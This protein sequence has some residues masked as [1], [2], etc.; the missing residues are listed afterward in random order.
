MAEKS[1]NWPGIMGLGEVSKTEN[2]NVYWGMRSKKPAKGRIT[3]GITAY[4]HDLDPLCCDWTSNLMDA[5]LITPGKIENGGI[6]DVLPDELAQY[7][8]CHFFSGIAGWD[9]ALNLA[10]WGARKVFTGSVPCQPFSSAGEGKGFADERHLWPFFH[11]IIRECRPVICFGEQV[12][13]AIEKLWLDLLE[14]DLEGIGYA[15]GAQVFPACS[16]GAHHRR[17]RL[18][19]VADSD[20]GRHA[21]AGARAGQGQGHDAMRSGAADGMALA[22][23]DQQSGQFH[24]GESGGEGTGAEDREGR[25][26]ERQ[27]GGRRVPD[28]GMGLADGFGQGQRRR[29]EGPGQGE[30]GR[31]S[32]DDGNFWDYDAE[33]RWCRDGKWRPIKRN[34]LPLV[35]GVHGNVGL[36]R[37]AGNSIVPQQGAAFVQAFLDT[38]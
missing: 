16:V 33:L 36:V 30:A 26:A 19:W 37:G 21:R 23:A 27:L 29:D 34:L 4:Y 25:H 2:P 32:K 14:D 13:G 31:P 20:P 22:Y 5:G 8:R 12:D 7:D 18:Y 38:Y 11:H 17:Q 3:K 15:V 28:D 24:G 6:E 1:C 10:G 9:H 35:D